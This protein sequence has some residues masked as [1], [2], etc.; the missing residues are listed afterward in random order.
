MPFEEV[1]S[2]AVCTLC[3][4]LGMV[5]TVDVGSELPTPMETLTPTAFRYT[6]RG[7]GERCMGV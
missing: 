6:A 7:R 1:S 5:A 3:T 2:F 4:L